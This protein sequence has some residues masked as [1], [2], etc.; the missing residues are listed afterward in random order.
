MTFKTIRQNFWQYLKEV[1]PVLYAHG[2]RSKGQNEQITDIRCAF[3]EYIE[4]L[5]RSGQISEKTA[6]NITL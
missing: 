1:D 3:V 5:R 6:N 4:D 2:K